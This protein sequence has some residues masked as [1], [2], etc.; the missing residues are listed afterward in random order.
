VA[1]EIQRLAETVRTVGD[2]A[3]PTRRE[4]ADA[5]RLARSLAQTVPRDGGQAGS[6]VVA[7]LGEAERRSRA[8]SE[9]LA[10][11]DAKADAF[12]RRLA[13]GGGGVGG[14]SIIEGFRMAV[15]A[16][17]SIPVVAL[18]GG[19]MPRAVISQLPVDTGV[20]EAAITAIERGGEALGDG[21]E[22][23]KL[24]DEMVGEPI[25][26]PTYSDTSPPPPGTPT[27]TW[28]PQP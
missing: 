6:A 23:Q 20:K 17:L 7:A 13:G 22:A 1:S 28:P 12:A 15:V 9:A 3:G 10:E 5:A 25:A 16:G 27:R 24:R 19:A 18:S 21:A 14:R 26:K 4:L 8:A 11:F 2:A